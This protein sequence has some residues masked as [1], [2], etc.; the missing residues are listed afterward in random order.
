M[1]TALD[2]HAR[3]RPRHELVLVELEPR[4]ARGVHRAIVVG[5]RDVERLVRHREP[6]A[7][8]GLLERHVDASDAVSAPGELPVGD[9]RH[10]A[11]V[12]LLRD[13]LRAL[14]RE[15]ERGDALLLPE[16]ERR[17]GGVRAVHDE[18]VVVAERRRREVAQRAERERAPLRTEANARAMEIARTV[19]RLAREED[20]E[21]PEHEVGDEAARRLPADVL[22]ANEALR[23]RSERG[24][25][26]GGVL[27]DR[28]VDPEHRSKGRRA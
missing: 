17:V 6:D 11:I 27:R 2:A 4:R 8:R 20:D 16:R 9:R 22:R 13:V 14:A 7:L 25:Q 19:R 26:L 18:S 3:R 5:Q 28:P 12:Q 24:G 10:Q 21:P 23:R 1:T 15:I